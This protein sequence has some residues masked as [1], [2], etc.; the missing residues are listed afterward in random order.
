[1]RRDSRLGKMIDVSAEQL[2]ALEA[3]LGELSAVYAVA[4]SFVLLRI[5]AE[6]DWLPRLLEMGSRLRGLLRTAR[7][8]AAEVER[9]AEEILDLRARWR[10]ALDQVRTSPAYQSALA[11]WA[12]NDQDVL[13]N[14]IPRVFAG[15]LIVQPTPTLFFPVSPSSGRRRPGSSPFLSVSECA[16]RVVQLLAA[17]V[18]P[19]RGGAE[20]WEC[21]LPYIAGADAPAALDTPISLR[22]AAPDCHVAVFGVA[23]EPTFRIFTPRLQATMAVNLAP[24]AT[25]EWW[26]AYEESF[27]SFRQALRREL[28][29][30]GVSVEE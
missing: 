17:G 11:A 8:S 30:G 28:A 22:L 29:R 9:A 5:R 23:D 18:E 3:A 12:A 27:A 7:L 6:E 21:E 16:Q 15:V 19:D 4:R 14:V 10:T 13:A 20:W 25:D 2:I 26:Q 24:E 1:L